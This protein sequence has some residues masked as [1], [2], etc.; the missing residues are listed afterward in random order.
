MNASS[1]GIN[2]ALTTTCT[3]S[4]RDRNI[5][6]GVNTIDA[7][8]DAEKCVEDINDIVKTID[9]AEDAKKLSAAVEN[10]VGRDKGISTVF[11]CTEKDLSKWKDSVTDLTDVELDQGAVF[12]NG[13]VKDHGK[14]EDV[15]LSLDTVDL[16]KDNDSSIQSEIANEDGHFAEAVDFLLEPPDEFRVC[17]IHF[18]ITC[19]FSGLYNTLVHFCTKSHETIYMYR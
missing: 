5:H 11:D 7:E 12:C 8:R 16:S 2:E 18:L 1:S 15:C 14:N 17:C 6:E 9:K 13:V 4:M 3:H 10:V 19:N